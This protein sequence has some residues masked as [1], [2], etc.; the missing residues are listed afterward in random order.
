[1]NKKDQQ[2]WLLVGVFA[3]LALCIAP[4]IQPLSVMLNQRIFTITKGSTLVITGTAYWSQTGY[5]MPNAKITWEIRQPTS[6]SGVIV[7]DYGDF[8]TDS[9]GK[10][11]WSHT[12]SQPVGQYSIY[13]ASY[14]DNVYTDLA[15][16]NIV[17]GTTTSTSSTST[18]A[19]FTT[20]TVTTTTITTSGTT[21]VVTTTVNPPPIL[22][23]TNEILIPIVIVA[24]IGSMG[25]YLFV[26]RRG[27]A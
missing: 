8:T 24:L 2:K 5:W 21:S 27:R 10:F 19:T 26:T 9:M 16:V 4:M 12:M 11:T 1:M 3:I 14:E 7:I 6:G 23:I 18:T 22:L 17:A 25:A 20:S 13:F 15:T